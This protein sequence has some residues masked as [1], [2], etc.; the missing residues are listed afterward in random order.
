VK[1]VKSFPVLLC[2]KT[3]MKAPRLLLMCTHALSC[4]NG[5]VFCFS[6]VKFVDFSI[7]NLSV[8]LAA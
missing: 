5:V 4:F 8:K 7:I 2:A 3:S 6:V 1:L